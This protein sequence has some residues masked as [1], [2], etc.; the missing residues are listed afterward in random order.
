MLDEGDSVSSQPSKSDRGI[1]L[2]PLCQRPRISAC[3]DILQDWPT[4]V[5]LSSLPAQIQELPR[6]QLEILPS[7]QE[8]SSCGGRVSFELCKSPRATASACLVHAEKQIQCIFSKHPAVYKIGITL[9][10]VHRWSHPRYGYLHDTVER[11]QGMKVIFVSES[12]FAAALVESAM[13]SKFKNCPGCRN[14]K[15]GGETASP[16]RG[17]HFTYVVYRILV[18]PPRPHVRSAGRV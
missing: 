1:P 5:W 17:P 16:E 7:L 3:G 2:L 18:P 6:L 13:I 4:Q 8:T 14:D 9:N 11:W 10:P 15:P 12:S